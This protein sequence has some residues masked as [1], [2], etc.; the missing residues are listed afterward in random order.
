M[1]SVRTAYEHGDQPTISREPIQFTQIILRYQVIL[2]VKW[3]L[4]CINYCVVLQL[5]ASHICKSCSSAIE[6]IDVFHLL[7]SA[8]NNLQTRFFMCRQINTLPCASAFLKQ[9]VG[10]PIH[11][12]GSSAAGANTPATCGRVERDPIPWEGAPLGP[13]EHT[14]TS[15]P[16]CALVVMQHLV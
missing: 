8:T 15:V 5:C 11:S 12:T 14:C 1:L 2:C 16:S 6:P 4:L 10:P 3:R 13:F 9:R 7:P